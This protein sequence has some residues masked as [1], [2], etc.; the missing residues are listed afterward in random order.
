MRP[1][2][3]DRKIIGNGNKGVDFQEI[4]ERRLE[5]RERL[6]SK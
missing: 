5:E 2:E 4:E 3:K 1:H 6:R